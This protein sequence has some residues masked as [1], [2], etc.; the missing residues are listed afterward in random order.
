MIDKFPPL[1]FQYCHILIQIPS[2][3]TREAIVSSST[4]FDL[5]C[6]YETCPDSRS[7]LACEQSPGGAG[8]EQRLVTCKGVV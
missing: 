6:L 5:M 8:A 4:M 7:M 2:S 3:A 1:R